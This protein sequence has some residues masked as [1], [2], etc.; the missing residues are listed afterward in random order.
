MFDESGRFSSWELQEPE[1]VL[2][3]WASVPE[4]ELVR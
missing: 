2:L 3:A 4:R 1:L